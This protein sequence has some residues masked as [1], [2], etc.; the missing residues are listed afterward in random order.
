MRERFFRAL[1]G[2][3]EKH[4]PG[5]VRRLELA[6][7]TR[8]AGRSFGSPE[9]PAPV[10][11]YGGLPALTAENALRRYA[12]L[13]LCCMERCEAYPSRLYEEA[14]R[15]GSRI[16][17]IT[18]FEDERDMER[19]VFCLYRNI[20]I[21]MSGSIRDG[22]EIY[23]CYF[24]GFYTPEQCALMSNVDSGIVAGIC[25]GGRLVFTERI[26]E[27]CGRC[28]ACLTEGRDDQ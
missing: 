12:R 19:L 16:R 27:G 17:R 22:F 21:S 11:L 13:T 6:A 3:A 26:T 14:F 2:F 15:L 24:S 1:L 28:R 4:E 25:G 7:L 20:G 8:L 9:S 5:C 10:R 18:G 23:G